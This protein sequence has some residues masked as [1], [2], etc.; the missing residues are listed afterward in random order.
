MAGSSAS[1][2]SCARPPPS[3][4]RWWSRGPPRLCSAPNSFSP[5]I[6]Q[7]RPRLRVRRARLQ[8]LASA[9][10]CVVSG[11]VL[12]HQRTD[13]GA[14]LLYLPAQRLPLHHRAQGILSSAG[15]WR[16]Q[17][18]WSDSPGHL[19]RLDEGQ[20][21]A[22]CRHPLARSRRQHHRQLLGYGPTGAAA[23]QGQLFMTLRARSPIAPRRHC[24]TSS[25]IACARRSPAS[26]APPSSCRRSRTSTSRA[27]QRHAV[28]IHLTSQ[29]LEDLRVWTPRM[30]ERMLR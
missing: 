27:R 26:P 14:Y 22:V 18:A 3:W 23:N 19:L 9:A 29:N 10:I 21:A 8:S 17:A 11:W 15:Y 6:A 25:S 16:L 1:S 4:S 2:P 30:M 24:G 13:A 5:C 7:A 20:D 28:P 12:T